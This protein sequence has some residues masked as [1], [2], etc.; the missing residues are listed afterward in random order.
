[1]KV[2]IKYSFIFDPEDT[3]TYKEELDK[4]IASFFATKGLEVEVI[5]SEKG[6][7]A[8]LYI[9]KA[10]EGVPT[11]ERPTVKQKIAQLRQKRS[12]EGRFSDGGPRRRTG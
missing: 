6:H 11:P 5:K 2:Y 1:M 10:E 9:S 7:E 12:P 3:W 4:D 8:M